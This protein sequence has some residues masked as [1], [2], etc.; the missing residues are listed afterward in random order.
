M[1]VTHIYHWMSIYVYCVIGKNK[2][3]VR[4][5]GDVVKKKGQRTERH[6]GIRTIKR[7]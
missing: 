4:R 5:D 6:N 3:R 1:D 7:I 2:H